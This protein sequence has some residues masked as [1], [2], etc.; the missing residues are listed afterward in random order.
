VLNNRS[1]QPCL[2]REMKLLWVRTGVSDPF[3]ESRE[4]L[5]APILVGGDLRIQ[6]RLTPLG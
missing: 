5:S 1:G 6:L 3:E 4:E 2:F